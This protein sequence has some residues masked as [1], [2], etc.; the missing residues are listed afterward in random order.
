LL[1]DSLGFY[2]EAH[3]FGSVVRILCIIGDVQNALKIA[4][5][6]SE[7]QACFHLARYYETNNNMREAIVYYSKSQRLTHAIKLAKENG[8][9]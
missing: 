2:R 8:Y 1:N 3:D 4:L 9:D 7:P 5:E 6:T